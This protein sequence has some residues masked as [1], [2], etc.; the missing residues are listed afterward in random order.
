MDDAGDH[1]TSY[2]EKISDTCVPSDHFQWE[3]WHAAVIRPLLMKKKK[4]I[5]GTLKNSCN[6]WNSTLVV[7]ED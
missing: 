6:L 7:Y 4:K 5:K 1:V 2:G 3:N